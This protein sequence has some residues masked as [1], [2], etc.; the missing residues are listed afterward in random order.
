MNMEKPY[1]KTP[2]PK[3]LRI[4]VWERYHA[5]KYNVK[6]SVSWC[7][8]II[9][10]FTFEAGHNIPESKGGQTSLDNLIPICV[11]CNRSMGDR[12]TITEFSERF[13]TKVQ[14]PVVV[15]KKGG[16][17]NCFKN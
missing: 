1:H 10:P 8:N 6:C 5:N 15:H 9:N 17:F 13:V 3:A 12:Y 14:Q 11:S 2:I 16:C 7:N 4:A